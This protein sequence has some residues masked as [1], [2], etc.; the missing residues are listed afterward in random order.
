MAEKKLKKLAKKT[1]AKAK[2]AK[3]SASANSV[4]ESASQIWLAGLGAFAKAQ[5]EGGKIFEGLVKEGQ[6]LDKKT[7]KTTEARVEEVRGAFEGTISQMQN[8]A[9]ESWDK[10]ERVFEERVARALNGLGVPT[11]SDIQ[12]LTKRVDELQKSVRELNKGGKKPAAKKATAKK[13]PAKK[14]VAK[15]KVAKK[16]VAKK[17]TS[18]K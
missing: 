5:E 1:S 13:A 12:D 3:T 7:R 8:R 18:K 10:L 9:S 14:K 6:K 17:K 4:L 15:K 11:S 16:K 2:K